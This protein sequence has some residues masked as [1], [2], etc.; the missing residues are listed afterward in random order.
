MSISNLI[1]SGAILFGNFRQDLSPS[2]YQAERDAIVAVLEQ[3]HQNT[4][5]KTDVFDEL[6][7][8]DP[9]T[10]NLVKDAASAFINAREINIDSNYGDYLY[11][12]DTSGEAHQFSL[13]RIVAHELIH[14][15]LGQKDTTDTLTGN[16]QPDPDYLG[17]T[18]RE[19]NKYFE[20]AHGSL[21]SEPGRASYS[22]A[23]R[24]WLATENGGDWLPTGHTADVVLLAYNPDSALQTTAPTQNVNTS[25]NVSKT[26]DLIIGISDEIN[27]IDTG[28][29][30]DYIYARGGD[31]LITAGSGSDYIDGGNG[32]DAASYDFDPS[33]GDASGPISQGIQATWGAGTAVV[34]DGYG[35]TDQLTSIET[36]YGT[37]FDDLIR[38]SGDL[39]NII[40]LT[41]AIDS[42]A[43]IIAN[44]S[45]EILGDTLALETNQ[46]ANVSLISNSLAFG[47]LETFI[48]GFENVI[49][50]AF[51][52]T[53]TGNA[54]NNIIMGGGGADVIDGGDG[55]DVVRFDPASGGVT[56][57]LPSM[58]RGSAYDGSG[59]GGD[60]EGDV[61]SN[62][63]VFIGTDSND[64]FIDNG[65]DDTAPVMVAGGNGKDRV[66]VDSID[67]P[68]VFWGGS[69]A[70]EIVSASRIM[71]VNVGNLTEEN[72]HLFELDMIGLG[73]S[74]KWDEIDVVLL[75][76]DRSDKIIGIDPYTSLEY[77]ISTEMGEISTFT[78]ITNVEDE[79]PEERTTSFSYQSLNYQAVSRNYEIA[80]DFD[81]D[82]LGSAAHE[83]FGPYA[84]PIFNTY[85]ISVSLE[86]EP[87]DDAPT[88]EG[89]IVDVHENLDADGNS[90]D[91]YLH[92][93]QHTWLDYI[94]Y[95]NGSSV[96]QGVSPEFRIGYDELDSIGTF[97]DSSQLPFFIIGGT[98]EGQALSPDGRFYVSLPN[99]DG[100][101]GSGRGSNRT[102]Y[103]GSTFGAEITTTYSGFA[104]A[105]SVFV[106][107]S[108]PVDPNAPVA[109]TVI[110]QDGA[111]VLISSSDGDV[112]LQDVDLTEWQA[113]AQLQILGASGAETL[114]A[115][116]SAEVI[117]SGA[118]DDTIYAMSG[119]DTISYVSGNDR[120][121]GHKSNYGQDTL[122][123]SQYFAGQ[124]SFRI[125]GDDIFIFTPE[126]E[127]ELDQQAAYVPRHTRSNIETILLADGMLDDAA[128][129]ERALN[130]QSTAGNDS[131]EGSRHDDLIVDG[132]GNDTIKS[133]YGDDTIIYASGDDV[134]QNG[135]YGQDTL[136]LSKYTSGQ[137]SFRNDVHD[138]FIDT[139]DGMIELDYQTRYEAGHHVSNIEAF[140]FSDGTFTDVGI[141]QRA[142]DDPN[143]SG[144]DSINGTRYDDIMTTSAG[145]DTLNAWI[146]DDTISYGSGNDR[147]ING[148]G[149]DTLILSQYAS[150]QVTFTVAVNDVF[151]TTPD[152]T[153]D[154]VNQ[155]RYEIGHSQTNIETLV[156]SDTTLD[157]AGIRQ[158]ALDDQNGSGDDFVSGTRFDDL[159][160]GGAGND[161]FDGNGGADQFS[162][163][164]GDGSDVIVD[165]TVDLDLI[166]F[167]GGP[168]G[169]DDLTITDVNGDA[170]IGYGG[171]D[172]I[173][174][175]NIASY[176]LTEDDFAFV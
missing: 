68:L 167:T 165:F 52:D 144:D 92:V 115:S 13:A 91:D 67:V 123:L 26:K 90:T 88:S 22:A 140:I 5:F 116:S 16:G 65:S 31:D 145:N 28:L 76:P 135:N 97:H 141:R 34:V 163:V 37:G 158:R 86:G 101:L 150:D 2:E 11:Y 106:L 147:I 162:F 160:A 108:A 6:S 73:A 102:N 112:V 15:V 69:G 172:S 72:F 23:G 164:P 175:T 166:R 12:L 155:A 24:G 49:G 100:S 107:N 17:D 159:I 84:T 40:Q 81:V 36:L 64:I 173:A 117:V 95:P 27:I 3:L 121:V 85:F 25:K 80:G 83:V 46:G 118:G 151:I 63:E 114:Y 48:Y 45:Y 75:N 56:I 176:L 71:L 139:P 129:R 113:A 74:F 149:H 174:L 128:I 19:T 120:I 153:I 154:L 43:A 10:I 18:V 157:D 89:E 105:S 79:E 4:S 78:G 55:I 126:G 94:A 32:D 29:G 44:N 70:D 111:N 47:T 39:P 142:M 170:V 57:D 82:F 122:D 137:V 171:N 127:I 131:I 7:S 152:G 58:W 96:P 146:G 14:A 60:A 98:L 1:S 93:Q 168:T 8:A 109:G 35:D 50:S 133:W 38:I 77:T 59:S 110:S 9:L 103:N 61:Y 41:T 124:V 104:A 42:D 130:D 143:T 30:D 138:I 156:L 134:I 20:N 87:L 136:D 21:P 125:Q 132:A 119:D 54:E 169:F 66:E 51:G 33:T 53:I 62:I 148:A 161:T 99:P